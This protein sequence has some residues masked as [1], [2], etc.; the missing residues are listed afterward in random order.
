MS[1][2]ASTRQTDREH[3]RAKNKKQI[4]AEMGISVRTLRRRLQA[5]QL[6]VPR[7]LIS[8]V[9]QREIRDQLGWKEE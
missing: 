2:S 8:P 9:K 3:C 7:G 4:A 1:Q 5:F 6:E